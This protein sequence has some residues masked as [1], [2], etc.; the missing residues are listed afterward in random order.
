MTPGFMK[1]GHTITPLNL[2][3]VPPSAFNA[4]LLL[5]PSNKLLIIYKVPVQM[6]P[7][8]ERFPGHLTRL[9]RGYSE[10]HSPW[11]SFDHGLITQVD[12][13]LVYGFLPIQ[14]G[15]P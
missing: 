2:G 6:T 9:V 8:L 11:A 12:L 7:P 15:A 14:S 1:T 3:G 13:V 10:F 4:L 5:C